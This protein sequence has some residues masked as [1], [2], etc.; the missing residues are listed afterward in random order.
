[1]LNLSHH[2][3]LSGFAQLLADIQSAVPGV[4]LLIVGA[5]ARDLILHYG[6]GLRIERATTDKDFA[7]AAVDWTQ[8][9]ATRDALVASGMFTPYGNIMHRLRHVAHGWIDLIPF[10]A[11][12]RPDGTIAWPP[13]H[14]E[15]MAVV[16]YSEAASTAITVELP[17]GQT[18]SV[19]SLPML[20]VLKLLAWNERHHTT[21]GKDADD[22]GLILRNYL[23]AGN[24]DRLFAEFP[25]MITEQFDY[26]TV[27][28]WMLGNDMRA[29]L[30]AG[31]K[32]FDEII[33]QLDAI[34][35]R[36]LSPN[37]Q[38]Q[39]APQLSRAQPDRALELLSALHAG[40]MGRS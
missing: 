30:R 40:L 3:E 25:Q 15:V 23:D 20:A 38:L 32:R 29:S 13:S 5:F 6:H 22:L 1:M 39:L 7:F 26:E 21:H 8:F 35:V 4:E 28:A 11:V 33:R 36:E 2:P 27:G 16:G 9:I 14:D 10:G 24:R 12:E 18:A 37:G 17:N 31:S 34:L 19:V